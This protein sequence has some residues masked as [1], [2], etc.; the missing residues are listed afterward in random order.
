VCISLSPQ[1][2]RAYFSFPHTSYM[3]HQYHTSWL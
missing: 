3:P 2:S 1:I